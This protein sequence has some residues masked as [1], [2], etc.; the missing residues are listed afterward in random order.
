MFRKY[1]MKPATPFIAIQYDGKVDTL[2]A[3]KEWSIDIDMGLLYADY[4]DDVYFHRTSDDRHIRINIGNW[5][6]LRNGQVKVFEDKQFKEHYKEF[7]QA[8]VL[9]PKRYN[10]K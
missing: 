6:T 1:V 2:C 4:K 5:L 8:A 10:L 3:I 9:P 7:N